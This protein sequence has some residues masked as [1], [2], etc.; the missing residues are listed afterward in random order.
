[1]SRK[2]ILSAVFDC[3]VYLQASI[4]E[5]GPAAELLRIIREMD[6]AHKP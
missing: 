3:M 5:A 6:L 2:K 4:S 1:M